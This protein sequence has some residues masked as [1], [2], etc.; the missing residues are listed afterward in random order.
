MFETRESPYFVGSNDVDLLTINVKRTYR[1]GDF[2]LGRRNLT[3]FSEIAHDA[4]R[5]MVMTWMPEMYGK[6]QIK[7]PASDGVHARIYQAVQ[8]FL[9]TYWCEAGNQ[10]FHDE[11]LP[12]MP[13][14]HS[15]LTEKDVIGVTSQVVAKLVNIVEFAFEAFMG[16]VIARRQEYL[17][18]LPPAEAE[19][20]VLGACPKN[21][22]IISMCQY[23]RLQLSKARKALMARQSR[24]CDLS[25]V[26]SAPAA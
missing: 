12:L 23:E 24:F 14:K 20:V 3:Q 26:K 5:F 18:N 19:E 9:T 10:F 2:Y 13:E 6:P 11:L 22:G 7:S 8:R 25:Q 16:T 1:H 21:L 4:A 15:R 17:P